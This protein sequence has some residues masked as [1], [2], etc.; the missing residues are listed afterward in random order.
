MIWDHEKS[1]RL[2]LSELVI[3]GVLMGSTRL[4]SCDEQSN[5]DIL[6]PDSYHESRNT[7]KVPVD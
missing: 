4:A 3:D 1:V 6:V 7:Q 5:I 2:R